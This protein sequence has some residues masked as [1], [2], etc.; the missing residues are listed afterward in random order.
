MSVCE[1]VDVGTGTAVLFSLSRPIEQ[2]DIL[3][4]NKRFSMRQGAP[5]VLAVVWLGTLRAPA[6]THT[7]S[8][9]TASIA[10]DCSPSSVDG[11][12]ALITWA[13]SAVSAPSLNF[14][15]VQ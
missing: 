13:A 1:F 5:A 10:S 15:T 4:V 8:K 14:G 7:A 11:R 3:K 9:N 12:R 6:G 2:N